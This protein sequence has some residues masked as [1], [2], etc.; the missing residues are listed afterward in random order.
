MQNCTFR[1]DLRLGSLP[2]H[3]LALT[4]ACGAFAA[5]AQNPL[6]SALGPAAAK[7]AAKEKSRHPAEKD[8]VK[9]DISIPVAPLGFAPP[10]NFYLGDRF[11]QVSLNFLDEDHLLFTFRVPGLMAREPVSPGEPPSSQRHIRALTLSLPDG[12]VTAESLWNL[13]DFSRYLW[14]LKDG[15][16]LLRD[17]N[18]LQVGDAS[19]RLEPYLRFPGPVSSIEFDPGQDLLVADTIEPP[20]PAPK[21]EKK[22]DSSSD[23]AMQPS[24]AAASMSVNGRLDLDLQ[25]SQAS[26]Q[27]L[28]RV[29]NMESRKV[30]LFSRVNGTVH[31]PIDGEGYYEALRGNGSAWMI[32]FEHFRGSS[33][34]LQWLESACNP[35]LDALAPGVVLAS[36]CN[37]SGGRRLVALTRNQDKEHSKLWEA[38]IQPTLIW[39]LF[40][41]SAG[42]SRV[43]R[44]TLE[45][46]HP[47]GPYNPLDDSDIRGQLVQVYDLANGKVV[48][49][50]EASPILDGGGN[51]AL[52]PSGELFAIL[53]AGAIQ[54]FRLPPAPPIPFAPPANATFAK[55]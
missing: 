21:Q 8:A 1:V 32:N 3:A 34:P 54:V 42:G 46:S 13:H 41:S 15:R 29:F 47:I 38:S 6:V 11:V 17:R 53:N 55:P 30:M 28:L 23:S 51:F 10:A 9:P 50:V 43:A 24:T 48:L 36:A 44:S 31:L 4:L 45:V 25:K 2:I 12:K 5:Q 40:E 22:E 39:P 26:T 14:M 7:A 27:S 18:T 19:L 52:S 20:A 35:S 49:A 33:T 37:A 16:F